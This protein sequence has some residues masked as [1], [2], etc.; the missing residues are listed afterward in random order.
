MVTA[1]LP[2]MPCLSVINLNL[3]TVGFAQNDNLL[4]ECNMRIPGNV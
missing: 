3:N 2:L 4:S 1:H